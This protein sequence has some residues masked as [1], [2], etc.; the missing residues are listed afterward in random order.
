MGVNIVTGLLW[1]L[2]FL[3]EFRR[4]N[5]LSKLYYINCKICKNWNFRRLKIEENCIFESVQ[6][7]KY[8][9]LNFHVPLS[10]TCSISPPPPPKKKNNN[11]TNRLSSEVCYPVFEPCPPVRPPVHNKSGQTH[12]FSVLVWA[13]PFCKQAFG[14]W[15]T[16]LLLNKHV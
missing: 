2:K 12:I 7:W 5:L 8:F 6:F 3:G 15:E 16:S 11:N 1:Y 13:G 4:E 14:T 9:S 10:Y